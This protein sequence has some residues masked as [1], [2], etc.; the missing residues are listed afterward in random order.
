MQRTALVLLVFLLSLPVWAAETTV[1]WDTLLPN[2]NMERHNQSSV[3]DAVTFLNS[4]NAEWDSWA[5][6]A[7]S[8]FSNTVAVNWTNQYAAAEARSNAYAVAYHS[9]WDPV[10]E[11]LFDIPAAPHSLRI[12]NTTWAAGAIRDGAAPARAFTNGDTFVLTLTARDIEGTTLATT[13]HYLA[14]FRDGKT[15]I[16]TNWSELNLSAFPPE[17][18]SIRGT[19]VTT[20]MGEWG[21]NTPMYFALADM[22]YAYADSSG[23]I[24]STNPFILCWADEVI[25]Y[26]PGPNVSNQFMIATNALGPADEG[27]GFNGST[28]VVSLGDSG[29]ITLTF[30]LPITDG[31]G[32]DFAVFENAFSE[33]FLEL[34]FVEV[35]SDGTN[36]VRFANHSLE[37]DPID[38]YGATNISDATA[39]G[40][41]AGKHLQGFGTPFDL[42][43]LVG[44]AG[45][46]LL[47]VTHVRLVDV[48]GDGTVLD[49]YGNPV[50]D[51]F[52][53]W[54]SGG[55]DLDAVGVMH[56]RI[57][58]ST[59]PGAPV[60]TLPGFVTVQEYTPTLN[61]PAWTT[62]TPAP[63]TTPIFSR[64]KLTR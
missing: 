62:N 50:Y 34:A 63:D 56:A 22:K 1:S 42:H 13:N 59:D 49:T 46:D 47:R 26:Q 44:E 51:P 18:A 12:N 35:S 53:T 14:D 37:P 39:Y 57:D 61:P 2:P 17:V 9:A 4:Y 10:P 31:P 15:F 41:L 25:S 48:L 20:D 21:A 32:P 30:P 28:N 64:Y 11:I 40:N 36:F 52:P 55:F 27:D 6:F 5:G 8:T 58:I 24:G 19:L 33:D 7:L 43:E 23:G 45:I 54:G 16:Q 3:D 60:P 29:Q 38:T